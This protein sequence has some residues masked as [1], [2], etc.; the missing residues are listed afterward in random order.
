VV[1]HGAVH[2]VVAVRS[3]RTGGA[4]LAAPKHG[5]GLIGFA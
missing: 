3:C 2:D 1:D 5:E 4:D